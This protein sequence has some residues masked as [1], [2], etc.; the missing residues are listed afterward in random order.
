MAERIPAWYSPWGHLAGTVGVGVVSLALAIINVEQLKWAELLT[1]PLV[2]VLSNFIEWY[3]HKNVMHRRV[4]P[5]TVL[6]DRHTPEHHRVFRYADMAIRSPRELRMVLIPA[7]GVL[8]IVLM[9]APGA[10]LSGLLISSNVGWL[11]LL[12]SAL[13]VV[14]YELTHLCYHLPENSLIY[15]L[16]FM[17]KL[18]EHHARHH[19]PALMQN[20]NFNVTIPLADLV[21]KSIAPQELVERAQRRHG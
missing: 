5:M 3:V 19:E 8:G 21:F 6:Y 4:W 20:W 13:Y 9:Q 10:L 17:R 16:S 15:R 7:M 2:F 11:F 18:R 1:I 12:S 14:S